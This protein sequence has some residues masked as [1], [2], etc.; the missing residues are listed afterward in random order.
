MKLLLAF[1]LAIL[2]LGCSAG[3]PS[4]DDITDKYVL[5]GLMQ[6]C[7]IY[8]L[9]DNN[10]TSPIKVV[11]CPNATTTTIHSCGKGCNASNTVIDEQ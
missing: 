7:K 5:P 10:N 3:E 11:H 4:T 9:Y 6:E 2:M 8:R 1:V